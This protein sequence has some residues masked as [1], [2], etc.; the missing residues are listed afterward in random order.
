MRYFSYFRIIRVKI[1]VGLLSRSR[2][3]PNEGVA[4]TSVILIIKGMETDASG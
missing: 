3:H 1:K 4:H 2:L